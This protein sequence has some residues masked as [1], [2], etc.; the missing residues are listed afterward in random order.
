MFFADLVTIQKSE[1]HWS[2]IWKVKMHINPTIKYIINDMT[3]GGTEKS[4]QMNKEHSTI[5]N[6]L[7]L[8]LDKKKEGK[9]TMPKNC[10]LL[11]KQCKYDHTCCYKLNAPELSPDRVQNH[12]DLVVEPTLG[13]IKA[14]NRCVKLITQN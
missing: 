1:S 8:Q 6:N 12:Q 10:L 9:K 4:L 13:D 14:S 2:F 3:I 11:H 7:L 5:Q